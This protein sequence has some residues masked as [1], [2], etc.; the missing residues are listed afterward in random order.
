MLS[1]FTKTGELAASSCWNNVMEVQ[2]KVLLACLLHVFTA[3]EHKLNHMSKCS[4]APD[5]QANVSC[6]AW[7]ASHKVCTTAS[8]T[9][10]GENTL[11]CLC[12]VAKA[13][14]IEYLTDAYLI[15]I[16]S[17]TAATIAVRVTHIACRKHRQKRNVT[18]IMAEGIVQWLNLMFYVVPNGMLYSNPC[19]IT[20]GSWFWFG[21]ARWTCWNT[22][23]H[24]TPPHPTPPHPTPPHPIVI[25]PYYL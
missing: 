6:A 17:V 10:S 13:G 20:T 7:I 16:Y 5:H 2:L 25:A 14:L 11:S 1:D 12:L 21:F 18:L 15:A 3:H 4:Y 19:Y 23:S 22:V 8:Y 24:P 9:L